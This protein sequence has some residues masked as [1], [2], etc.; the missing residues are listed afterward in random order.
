[1][2]DR[3]FQDVKALKTLKVVWFTMLNALLVYGAIC[4]FLMAYAA[5]KPRYTPEVLHVPVFLGLTWLSVIY[6]FSVI[7]TAI[8]IA[9]FNR[10]HKALIASMKTQT[11]ESE[12]AAFAFLIKAYTTQMFIHLAIFDAVAIVGLV[13]FML[14]LDFTTL[15]NLLIIASVGF[16]FVMPGQAKLAY[17]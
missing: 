12:E 2:H 6:L 14:T 1:M 8:G 9:H 5:Y 3:R 10:V 17:R 7:V 4:Y 13:V 11:F 16:F 15:V